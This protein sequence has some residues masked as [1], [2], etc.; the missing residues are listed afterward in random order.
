MTLNE[1]LDQ[2]PDLI[3][4]T[5]ASEKEIEKAEGTLGVKFA[6]DYKEYLLNYGAIMFDGHELTG[7]SKADYLDVVKVTR[8]Q[9]KYYADKNA[10]EMYV[11]ENMGFDG[12]VVWQ[13]SDGAVYETENG[14][15]KIIAHSLV[16]YIQTIVD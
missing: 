15:R 10:T 2:V 9:R 1:I 14:H 3:A 6:K 12:I 11:I 8:N 7:I 4:G 5:G 16:E 13:T